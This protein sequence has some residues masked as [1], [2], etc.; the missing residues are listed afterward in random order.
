MTTIDLSHAIE[1]GMVTYPGLPAPHLELHLSREASRERYAPGY[2]FEIGGITLV[3][4][5]GTYLDT[6]LHRFADGWDLADLSIDA[7]AN[8][9]GLL[10]AG[11]ATGPTGIEALGDEDVSGRAVLVH[12]GWDAHFRTE[13][14]GD[15]DHPFLSEELAQALAD[16]GAALVGIDSV[17]IDG[18]ADGARPIHTIL[19]GAGIPI[20]EHLRGLDQLRG[21]AFTFTAVPP[22]FR[23]LGTFSVRAFAT[24]VDPPA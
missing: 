16:R 3:G 10:L 21:R 15:T 8:V 20:V 5:T 11:A 4:N 1:D 14:Y 22:P 17:N 13:R 23:G 2:E 12:T 18:T 6:P 24:I 7:V 9:P 19:L